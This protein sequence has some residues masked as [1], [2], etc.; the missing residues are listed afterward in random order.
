M[1]QSSS[2]SSELLLQE[3]EIRQMLLGWFWNNGR[4][5]IWREKLD[6]FLIIVAEVLLKKTRA[7]TVNRFLPGFLQCYGNASALSEA[8]FEELRERLTPL[9]LASQ[10]GWQLKNLGK[11]LKDR[12]EGTVPCDRD[13]LLRLPGMGDYSVNAVLSFAYGH[14]EAIVDTNIARVLTRI[15]GIIP[16]HH[17]ARRSP[18]IWGIAQRLVGDDGSTARQINWALLDLGALVCKPKSPHCGICPLNGKCAYMSHQ[19]GVGWD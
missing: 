13:E 5:F 1:S 6:P 3:N 18:E 14:A 16:S 15:C 17:E 11:A 9:G 2:E 4:R 10:R 8:S 12:H 19:N 7:E